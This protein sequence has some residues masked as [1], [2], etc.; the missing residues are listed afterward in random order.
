MANLS[1]QKQIINIKINKRPCFEVI[2]LLLHGHFRRFAIYWTKNLRKWMLL[3]LTKY[4]ECYRIF[5]NLCSSLCG[6][7]KN[8]KN[9]Y[10]HFSSKFFSQC[11]HMFVSITCQ[12][13]IQEMPKLHAALCFT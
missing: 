10:E 1:L 3:Y 9:L 12:H 7:A 2:R 4:F 5:Y 11:L 6:M 13:A 8:N